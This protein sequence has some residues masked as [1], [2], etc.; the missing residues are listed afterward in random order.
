MSKI[1]L[2]KKVEQGGGE[3]WY[4]AHTLPRREMTAFFQ[5]ERQGFRVFLPRH[6]KT[7]RHARKFRF[8]DAPLFPGYLFVSFDPHRHRWRSINGTIGVAN[9]IL[10]NDQPVAAPVGVVE[11]LIRST[12]SDGLLRYRE[13]LEPGQKIRLVAG[14]FA[15][16]LG[17]LV[18]LDD[19]GRIDVLLELMGAAVRVR[20]SRDCVEAAS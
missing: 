17:V 10:A 15:E 6:K 19:A 4:V 12:S 3:K 20:V 14:P 18:R 5:L 13:D 2:G 11:T 7:L 9:L 1:E 8:V 16:R